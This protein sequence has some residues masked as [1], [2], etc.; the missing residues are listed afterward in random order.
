MQKVAMLA[1][2]ILASLFITVGLAQQPHAVDSTAKPLA[3]VP[4]APA[5]SKAVLDAYNAVVSANKDFQIALL[6]ARITS[7]VD[8]TWGLDLAT[9]TFTPP[10]A[11]AAAPDSVNLGKSPTAP[12]KP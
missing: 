12:T 3:P 5:D 11:K 1:L 7:R 4:M 10:A 9:M 6:K 2:L 8:E